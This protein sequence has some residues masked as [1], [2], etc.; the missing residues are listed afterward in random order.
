MST[1]INWKQLE[2]QLHRRILFSTKYFCKKEGKGCKTL[3][4]KLPFGL[5]F[6]LETNHAIK[7]F[8]CLEFKSFQEYKKK[9]IR[10]P[11][12]APRSCSTSLSITT[13]YNC[14]VALKTKE[15]PTNA[16]FLHLLYVQDEMTPANI[17][18]ND[19]HEILTF[20]ICD[21]A[22][23]KIKDGQSLWFFCQSQ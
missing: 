4:T 7:N 6:R 12:R 9:K 23:S 1:I 14:S 15:N 19:L 20:L 11:P 2:L 21:A 22:D 17:H 18:F 8:R 13:C 16:A 3:P 10:H 5:E